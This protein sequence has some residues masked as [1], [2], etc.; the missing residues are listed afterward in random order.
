MIDLGAWA[1]GSYVVQGRLFTVEMDEGLMIPSMTCG[2]KPSGHAGP[3]DD[4][5]AG[6][7][8]SR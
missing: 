4:R 7:S 8:C 2:D 6:H 1:E 3:S 5:L